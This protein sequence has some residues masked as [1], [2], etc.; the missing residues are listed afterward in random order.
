MSLPTYGDT[1]TW[2]M[3]SVLRPFW[4]LPPPPRRC[5]LHSLNMYRLWPKNSELTSDSGE[6]IFEKYC[7][8]LSVYFF[9]APQV[10]SIQCFPG[11]ALLDCRILKVAGPWILIHDWKV[12]V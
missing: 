1:P 2:D 10:L 6:V 5:A 4:I 7:I 3:G 12:L 9:P 11:L 8:L